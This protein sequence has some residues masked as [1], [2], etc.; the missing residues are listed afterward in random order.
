M[1]L[2][3]CTTIRQTK[4]LEPTA[5]GME[6]IGPRVYASREV[7]EGKRQQ[8]LDA[9]RKGREKARAFYGGL[10]TDPIIVGCVDTDCIIDFG[11]SGDGAPAFEVT[12]AILLWPKVF[13]AGEVAHEWSH[14]ELHA[15]VGAS[16]A[17]RTIPNWFHEGLATVVADL[18][19]HSE[20]VYEKAVESGV[21]VP[22]LSELRTSAQW[23]AA[24]KKYPNPNGPPVVY[25]TAGHEVHTW[26]Q[27]V[28][29]PGLFELIESVKSG[30]E[31]DSAYERIG[32]THRHECS[33]DVT[34]YWQNS[35]FDKLEKPTE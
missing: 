3:G 21:A 16:G 26:L 15:R 13:G 34:P 32:R 33:K 5:H 29:K 8:L 1:P 9:Y 10:V 19:R 14:L 20:A 25:A 24:F 18:P 35:P 30:E 12:P 28:G 11:G 7:P 23:A 6:K 4:L 27:C 17:R 22:P 31:F 2:V